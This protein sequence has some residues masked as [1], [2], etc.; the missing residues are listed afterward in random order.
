M[1]RKI[2]MA[3]LVLLFS[4][5]IFP[6]SSYAVEGSNSIRVG[7]VGDAIEAYVNISSA[8]GRM[9][10]VP[11]FRI[12]ENREISL[13][14]AGNGKQEEG[15]SLTKLLPEGG[16][17][18]SSAVKLIDQAR[19]AVRKRKQ[20]KTGAAKSSGP[21]GRSAT[22]EAKPAADVNGAIDDDDTVKASIDRCNSCDFRS[23]PGRMVRQ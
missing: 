19:E 5:G 10:A 14:G 23:M 16:I 22:G 9:S 20:E 1:F 8:E 17:S 3:A 7:R 11:R 21:A 12:M 4:A 6:L 13:G 18:Y 15:K 2:A